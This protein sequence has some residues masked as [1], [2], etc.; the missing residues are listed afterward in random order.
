MSNTK[1]SFKA[2]NV[3]FLD[4][5][6]SVQVADMSEHV[7]LYHQQGLQNLAPRRKTKTETK[8]N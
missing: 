6:Y 7:L 5:K 8:R 2:K 3:S 4:A 1:E